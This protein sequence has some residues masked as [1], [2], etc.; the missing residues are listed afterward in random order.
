MLWRIISDNHDRQSDCVS[1]LS[2]FLARCSRRKR[3]STI[4]SR[5]P[6]QIFIAIYQHFLFQHFFARSTPE[7]LSFSKVDLIVYQFKKS[8]RK[9]CAVD[10]GLEDRAPTSVYSRRRSDTSAFNRFL[11]GRWG[12]LHEARFEYHRSQLV[13]STWS[14]HSLSTAIYTTFGDLQLGELRSNQLSPPS[15]YRF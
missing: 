2:N 7:L 14:I 13:Y 15:R 12:R 8:G 10:L 4:F 11:K 3:H 1:L 5:Q 9:H 6:E